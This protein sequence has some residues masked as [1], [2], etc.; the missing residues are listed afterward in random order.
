M[1]N[2]T[3]ISFSY[4]TSKSQRWKIFYTSLKITFWA[5]LLT[6]KLLAS[7]HGCITTRDPCLQLSI[8][9]VNITSISLSHKTPKSQRWKFF[10]TSLK[11]TPWACMLAAMLL[12]VRIFKCTWPHNYWESMST[13]LNINGKHNK[14][15]FELWNTEIPALEKMLHKFQEYTMSLLVKC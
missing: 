7:A 14:H 8:I 4:E 15:Q 2:T 9:M 13:T 11:S 5:C 12:A 1:V 6:V 10:Y 3:S